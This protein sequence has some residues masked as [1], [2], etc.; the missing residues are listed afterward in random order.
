MPCFLFVPTMLAVYFCHTKLNIMIMRHIT[1]L[2]I[3]AILL[4]ACNSGEQQFVHEP[5]RSVYHWRTTYDP[6]STELSF[7]K[8]H[9]VGRLY[10]HYFDVVLRDGDVIPEATVL[11]KNTP[12]ERLDVVPTVYITIEAMRRLTQLDNDD[13]MSAT[14]AYDYASRIVKRINAMNKHNQITGVHEV[15]VDCDWTLST[16]K[17]YFSLLANMREQLHSQGIALSVT[18]RLHQLREAEPP[19]DMGVLMLYN[20]GN[21]MSEKT[22]NSILDINDVKPYFKPGT[23]YDLPLDFAYPVFGWNVCYRN[24]KF[25]MLAS[26]QSSLPDDCV[27]R[28]EQPDYATIRQVK[29][30]AES[31]LGSDRPYSTI[32]YHLDKQFLNQYTNEEMEHIY[33]TR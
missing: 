2:L 20:T 11:F 12:D 7:M 15:Q 26:P 27:V 32:I 4:V 29:Q 31:T 6:D 22:H 33:G 25:L 8:S 13:Q 23:H 3:T 19:A 30:L 17:A 28:H 21:L 14:V 18:V 10:I 5:M 16:R 9:G 24:G 1:L